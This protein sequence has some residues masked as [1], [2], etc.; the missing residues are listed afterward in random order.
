VEISNA[1]GVVRQSAWGVSQPYSNATAL[2]Y[3]DYNITIYVYDTYDTNTSAVEGFEV[4]AVAPPTMPT[5][6]YP[7]AWA[8]R[9]LGTTH[10]NCTDSTDPEGDAFTYTLYIESQAMTGQYIIK[11]GLTTSD[12][13]AGDLDL[14]ECHTYRWKVKSVQTD[15]N[16]TL[17]YTDW[18]YFQVDCTDIYEI[19]I[20]SAF[21]S[22]TDKVDVIMWLEKNGQIMT[23]VSV[24]SLV[25][26]DYANTTV[27]TLNAGTIYSDGIYRDTYT[28]T[29]TEAGL[30]TL[31]GTLTYNEI[32]YYGVGVFDANTKEIRDLIEALVVGSGADQYEVRTSASYDETS[33]TVEVI[34]WIQ[35][36]G[37]QMT[38]I[39]SVTVV[40][41][42][43]ANTTLH[44]FNDGTVYTDGFYRATWTA[45]GLHG[46]YSLRTTLT[47]SGNT[48]YGG[49]H[50]DAGIMELFD[51]LDT[52]TSTI[53]TIEANVSSA[54]TYIGD[55][56][57]T[58]SDSTLF[59]Y[60]QFI[61]DKWGTYTAEQIYNKVVD[62]YDIAVDANS[63]SADVLTA[64]SDLDT[65]VTTYMGVDIR[66]SAS[67]SF[68]N[69][70][71]QIAV[72]YVQD[73]A[74]KDTTSCTLVVKDSDGTT[75]K[76]FTDAED[77]DH[78]YRYEWNTSAVDF[79]ANGL[80]G[81][82]TL[83]PSVVYNGGT[84]TTVSH[85]S[86]EMPDV[87]G[88][89]TYTAVVTPYR[90]S[91]YSVS[92]VGDSITEGQYLYVKGVDATMPDTASATVYIYWEDVSNAVLST[93]TTTGTVDTGVLRVQAMTP[94]SV[95]ETDHVR[96][97]ATKTDYGHHTVT[98][99][100]V[101]SSF[102]VLQKA[103]GSGLGSPVSSLE[104]RSTPVL[105][106]GKKVDIAVLAD[107][108]RPATCDMVLRLSKGS[109]VI[110]EEKYTATLVSG[111]NPLMLSF[112]VP[113]A[114]TGSY[115][116]AL[117]DGFRV[118]DTETFELVG[119]KSFWSVFE[120]EWK[121]PGTN[122]IISTK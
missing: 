86:A 116:M 45:T 112:P 118:R 24:P 69:D 25:M 1:S 60:G 10:M 89:T 26:K 53:N 4:I 30:Y 78:I 42:D 43:E 96:L 33:G 31:K 23:D 57:D 17:G 61:K 82:Y 65:Y 104:I 59:G 11:D 62:V 9:V 111:S 64:L 117:T 83:I 90:D 113:N 88:T 18:S 103:V 15:D 21:N 8:I 100:G 105:Q 76:T 68:V 74:I 19:K 91:G 5:L 122:I 71:L 77:A 6:T 13:N 28:I 73:G 101:S 107:A 93:T 72:A 37:V 50:F 51:A 87:Y 38:G 121:V 36:N 75:L 2:D 79:P 16:S 49:S 99:S 97:V 115:S 20:Q 27:T 54:L 66:T 70:E 102:S 44:N 48:Y 12:Y 41:K 35:K 84:F 3:G 39:S 46:L 14:L 108:S 56:T 52:M 95:T 47:Y 7:E 92:V 32:V 110:S 98:M 22:G 40:M 29:G 106:S 81:L 34:S 109:V 85:F 63:T 67:Y 80:T 119:G 120:F 94:S 55:P 114:D 58:S